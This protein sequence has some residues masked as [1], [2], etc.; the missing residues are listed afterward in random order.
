M[1]LAVT[2]LASCLLLA[3][4]AVAAQPSLTPIQN[5][6]DEQPS[7]RSL[8]QAP[9]MAAPMP[10]TMPMAMPMGMS[11]PTPESPDAKNE[12]T[13]TML[14]LGTTAAG[15]ALT[16]GAIHSKQGGMGTVGVLTLIVGPSAGHIYA[17]E[18]GHALGMSVLR[19]GGLLAFFVGLI[20][21]TSSAVAVDCLDCATHSDRESG[22]RLMWAGGIAFVAST[23]Y[24]IID[25]PRAARRRNDKA[26]M[27]VVAPSLVPTATGM[28]PAVGVSGRF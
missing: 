8:T 6:D 4:R 24:D 18:A 17:G 27:F 1:R 20:E 13:A 10:M 23:I 5:P 11:Y 25:A 14:A 3:A 16:A 12:N 9:P 22:S 26:R 21:A 7:T 28:A 19:G 2:L 15:L